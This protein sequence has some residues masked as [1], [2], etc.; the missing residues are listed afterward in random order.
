MLFFESNVI[1]ITN[2]Q[3]GKKPQYITN[4]LEYISKEID[5]LRY[6]KLYN[7]SLMN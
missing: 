1:V 6:L 4:V 5:D 2:Q 7:I 3:Q